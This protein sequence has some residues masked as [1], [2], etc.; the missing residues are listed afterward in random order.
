MW[1]SAGVGVRDQVESIAN[2]ND[3]VVMAL[4]AIVGTSIA[5]LVYVIRNGR[6][7]KDSNAQISAVN[8]AVNDIGPGEH[9]LWDKIDNIE[10]S[11]T[12]LEVDQE[13]FDSHGWETLP[14]D[15]NTAVG[16]TTTIRDLQ[17]GH[18]AVNEKLDTIIEELREHVVWEMNTKYGKNSG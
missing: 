9:R 3:Q 14:A 5:A 8:R 1:A 2:T 16:L 7:A 10:K 13:T 17:N 18:A 11:L 4:I 15:L 12:H 6:L